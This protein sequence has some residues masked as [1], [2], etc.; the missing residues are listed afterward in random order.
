MVRKRTF[1]LLLNGLSVLLLA[2]VPLGQELLNKE[3]LTDWPITRQ[4]IAK[5]LITNAPLTILACGI[6][7]VCYGLVPSWLFTRKERNR[8]KKKFIDRI[9]SELLDGKADMH[10]VTL[11]REI[12]Y[13]KA[14]VR[15]Y[16]SLFQ[17]LFSNNR[18]RWKLYVLPPKPGRY[19]AVDLR[20]GRPYQKN[21]ST[22]FYVETNEEKD[23]EGIA[24]YIRFKTC[25]ASITDLP[26]VNDV[27]LKGYVKIDDIK[28]KIVKKKVTQYMEDGYIKEFSSL[29]K[30]H[31]KARHFFGTSINKSDG[32]PWGVLL[33]D[34]IATESPFNP[35][36]EKRF[37]SF[38]IS[39][40]DMINWE[41]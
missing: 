15:N 30:M 21:S 11:F 24:G 34:S 19:L 26:D 40:Y 32:S 16:I 20:C 13:K 17:H 14:L 18:W 8:L 35:E 29:R 6:Y 22:M 38:A 4:I 25:K 2:L 9:H 3:L 23:C 7:T 33:I 36:L 31:S 12:S 41:T 28:S 5:I 1:L 37:D 10:R 27:D 39:V